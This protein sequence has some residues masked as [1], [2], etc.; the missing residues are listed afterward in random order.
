MVFHGNGIDCMRHACGMVVQGVCMRG[1]AYRKL[2]LVYEHVL[3]NDDDD[4]DDGCGDVS[5]LN[6]LSLLF[7]GQITDQ[8]SL[9]TYGPGEN[10][11]T[12]ANATFEPMFVEDIK[13]ADNETEAQAKEQCKGDVECLFDAASTN[14]V[15][16]GV[17]SR[18]INIKV[19]KENN[20]LSK[21]FLNFFQ[22]VYF[23]PLW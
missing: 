14:D 16:I 20:Q 8:E 12:F 7:L 10:V 13:W 18:E 5:S 19:E 23:L 11:S 22:K 9:F 17:A 6:C 2:L 3:H 21:M 4:N 15:S 1:C